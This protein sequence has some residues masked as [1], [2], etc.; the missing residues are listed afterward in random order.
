LAQCIIVSHY[1]EPLDCVVVSRSA[2]RSAPAGDSEPVLELDPGEP[3][4]MLENSVGWAWG[5]GGKE[6]RVGYVRTEALG[7]P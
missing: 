6:R 1:A 2:L 5:Y 7:A 3:F 4:A